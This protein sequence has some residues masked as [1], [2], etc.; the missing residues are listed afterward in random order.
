MTDHFSEK[1]GLT[2]PQPESSAWLNIAAWALAL[3]AFVL[4]AVLSSREIQNIPNDL[5]SP[6]MLLLNALLATA[7]AVGFAMREGSLTRWQDA[8]LCLRFGIWTAAVFRLAPPILNEDVLFLKN[9][10]TFDLPYVVLGACI[11]GGIATL[12]ACP[13]ALRVLDRH[14]WVEDDSLWE[15]CGATVLIFLVVACVV[16]LLAEKWWLGF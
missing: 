13:F 12:L 11:H 3:S 14:A 5:R 9:C 16:R 2:D 6:A 4:A 8:H 1:P 15:L 7:V 10:G